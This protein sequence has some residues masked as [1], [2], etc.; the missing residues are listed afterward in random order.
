MLCRDC[1]K[2]MGGY[3]CCLHVSASA[4]FGVE[5]LSSSKNAHNEAKIRSALPHSQFTM[6]N[7]VQSVRQVVTV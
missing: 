4:H 3:Q 6:G 7:I 5:S 2:A 1:G